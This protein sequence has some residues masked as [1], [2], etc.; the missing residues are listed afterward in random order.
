MKVTIKHRIIPCVFTKI[1]K[2][3]ERRPNKI[4]NFLSESIKN[5]EITTSKEKSKSDSIEFESKNISFE[6][7]ISKLIKHKL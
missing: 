3:V 7:I 6:E 5:I 2:K 1:L 4:S